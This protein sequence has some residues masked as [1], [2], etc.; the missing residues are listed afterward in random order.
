[1]Y[2]WRMV[3]YKD[4]IQSKKCYDNN[5]IYLKMGSGGGSNNPIINQLEKHILKCFYTYFP[6][7]VQLI[8]NNSS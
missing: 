6:D 2:T 7:T 4:L 1:M 5:N 3:V 8:N